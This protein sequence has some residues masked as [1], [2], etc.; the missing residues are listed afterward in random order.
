[1]IMHGGNGYISTATGCWQVQDVK[2][3]DV[4]VK[5]NPGEWVIPS[6]CFYGT[7]DCDDPQPDE[8]G[9]IPRVRW[10]RA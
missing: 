2:F 1:M 10:D 4:Q 9:W 7:L 3:D 5:L 8:N 6:G